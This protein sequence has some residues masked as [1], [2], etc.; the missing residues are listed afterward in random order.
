MTTTI[1]TSSLTNSVT[2][3]LTLELRRLTGTSGFGDANRVVREHARQIVEDFTGSLLARLIDPAGSL[4]KGG[5]TIAEKLS[6]RIIRD[7]HRQTGTRGR[8]DVDTVIL[9]RI[10]GLTAAFQGDWPHRGENGEAVDEAGQ[11]LEAA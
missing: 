2:M 4:P 5:S 6:N 8:V 9:K 1:Q 3:T 11:P 10:A 7:L